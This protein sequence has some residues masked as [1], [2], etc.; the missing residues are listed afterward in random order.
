MESIKNSMIEEI[1]LSPVLCKAGRALV[2]F[3]QSDLAEVANVAP[4]TV[5][6]FERGARKP[7]RNNLIAIQQALETFGVDFTTSD[8]G[9]PGVHLAKHSLA[10]LTIKCLEWGGTFSVDDVYLRP[11]RSVFLHMNIEP[12]FTVLV[13]LPVDSSTI[14]E[15]R[16]EL[17]ATQMARR[18]GKAHDAKKHRWGIIHPKQV[19]HRSADQFDEIVLTWEARTSTYIGN[20]APIP[21]DGASK[22]VV[23][24]ELVKID[25]SF[26]EPGWTARDY[27]PSQ[28]P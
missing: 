28:S 17:V 20:G 27:E 6:D 2:G 10:W 24:K 26:F 14:L 21:L 8:E 16:F 4:Q 9:S 3:T 12:G 1:K 5:V 19:T 15:Q 25:W 11:N 22:K 7:L 13:R 18:L 23:A